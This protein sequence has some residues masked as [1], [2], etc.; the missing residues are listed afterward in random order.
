VRA[1]LVLSASFRAHSVGV[2]AAAYHLGDGSL[3]IARACCVAQSI[4]GL[5]VVVSTDV[6]A[7]DVDRLPDDF[8]SDVVR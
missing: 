8:Y 3:F 1:C 5:L 4:F 6:L 2:R 7:D